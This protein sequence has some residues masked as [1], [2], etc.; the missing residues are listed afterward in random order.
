MTRRHD[1]GRRDRIIDATLD[2]IAADGV[3]GTSHRKVAALADV[4][5]GS[6]TYHFASM[7]TLL[8]EAFTRFATTQS[9]AFAE[10]LGAAA[11]AGAALEVIVDLVHDTSGSQREH[12]LTFELYT[13]AARR[14]EFRGITEGWMRA[15]RQ[16]LVRH[17]PD[18][19][20][21]VV[22]AYI[23]G[24]GIHV[25]LDTAPQG[26]EVT[27]SALEVLIRWAPAPAAHPRSEQP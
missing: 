25:A 5:L 18:A 12:V 22:D 2:C 14:A 10:R 27:R 23:E 13:L 9:T 15:S 19:A 1:P 20:A 6:M 21:R 26:R 8:V 3:A 7:D 11:D 17:F 16:A 4:P 24:A